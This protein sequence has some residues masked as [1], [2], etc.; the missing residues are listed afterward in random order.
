[1]QHSFAQSH[2][3]RWKSKYLQRDHVR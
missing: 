3:E 2:H 1:M